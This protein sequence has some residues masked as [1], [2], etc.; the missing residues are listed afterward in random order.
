MD[1]D[2]KYPNNKMNLEDILRQAKGNDD[3]TYRKA[4]TQEDQILTG[5]E[6]VLEPYGL[7][8]E[9]ARVKASRNTGNLYSIKIK[10]V[11]Q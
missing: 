11:K 4:K 1:R 6:K 8:V 9:N 3:P 10:I 2:I 5:I 7:F